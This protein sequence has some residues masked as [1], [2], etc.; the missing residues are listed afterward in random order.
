MCGIAGKISFSSKSISPQNIEKMTD[1]IKHRGP[2]D[3]GWMSP[4]Q[5]VGLGH[6]AL[7]IIDLSPLGHQPMRY[8]D[9]Y[10]IV[11]NGEIY[12]FQEK[13]D[14]LEKEGSVF[15]SHSDTEVIL[16]LY[17]KYREKCLDHLRGM[18]AFAIYDEKENTLF[19]L[20]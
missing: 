4:N 20:P 9:R 19:A 14:A 3:S 10:E 12:N 2:D 1:A 5:K 8:L 15:T 17:D 6:R 18:F 7:A 16:A 11:F 13:R